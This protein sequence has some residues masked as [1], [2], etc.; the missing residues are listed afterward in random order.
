[1][2]RN[3]SA[4]AT[5]VNL[6]EK[7]RDQNL[8]HRHNCHREMASSRIIKLMDDMFA[9]HG[10]PITIFSDQGPQFVSKEFEDFLEENNISHRKVQGMVSGKRSRGKPRQRWEKY[11]TDTFGTMTAASRVAEDRHQFRSDIWAATS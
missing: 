11:I 10:L 8:S 2:S 9:V 5:G 3:I 1:M 6:L 4:R 7:P